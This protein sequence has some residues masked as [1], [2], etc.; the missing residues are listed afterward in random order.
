MS[1]TWKT[2]TGGRLLLWGTNLVALKELVDGWQCHVQ[3]HWEIS[4]V[5]LLPSFKYSS[6]PNKTVY[7]LTTLVCLGCCNSNSIEWEATGSRSRLVSGEASVPG[8]LLDC[9]LLSMSSHVFCVSV[10]KE[11][12]REREGEGERFL[13][14][15]FSKDTTSI[16]LGSP[17]LWP[18]LTLNYLPKELSS[19]TVTLGVRASIGIWWGRGE[20]QFDLYHPVWF[21][22]TSSSLSLLFFFS[23]EFCYVIGK[24]LAQVNGWLGSSLAPYQNLGPADTL[25]QC[26]LWLERCWTTQW[27]QAT[28]RRNCWKTR[29]SL[30]WEKLMALSRHNH[31]GEMLFIVKF[32]TLYLIGNFRV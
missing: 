10:R 13:I 12:K 28:R 24:N 18:H 29:P 7:V 15:L 1:K 9:C 16:R 6:C 5:A 4:W 8:F 27:D 32:N 26:W 3:N 23:L 14:L 22:C 30:T 25:C 21:E 20:T 19:N 11:R 31:A 2:L 17:S